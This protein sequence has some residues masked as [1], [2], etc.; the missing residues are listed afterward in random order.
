MPS[1]S[2]RCF[3]EGHM[4]PKSGSPPSR[5]ANRTPIRQVNLPPPMPTGESTTRVY[6]LREDCG[7]VATPPSSLFSSPSLSKTFSTM[8][9]LR[10]KTPHGPKVRQNVSLAAGPY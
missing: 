10:R 9:C 2:G 6:K 4:A 7:G 3:V 5:K 8:P 1:H